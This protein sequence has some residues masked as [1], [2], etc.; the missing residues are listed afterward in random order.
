MHYTIFIHAFSYLTNNLEGIIAA[1][2]YP[3]LFLAVLLEGVPLLGTAVPGHV[4]IFVAGFLA[5]I[6]VLNLWWVL[7]IAT[8]AAI[9]GDYIGFF[10]GR[11]YGLSLID[12][13]KPYF[14]ITDD[15]INKA[16]E[17]LAK[18]TGKAMIIGRMNPLTRALMPFLV[19]TGGTSVTKFWVFNV[20]GGVIWAVGSIMIGYVLGFGYHAAAGYFGRAVVIAIVAAVLIIWGYRF[21]NMRFHIFRRY[22]LLVLALGILS[23][24]SLSKMVQDAWSPMPFMAGFD[25]WVYSFMAVHV[26]P[27]LASVANMVT[28]VGGTAVTG[29]LGILFSIYFAFRRKWRSA[30]IM[31][32]SICSASASV[33]FLKEFFMRPRPLHGLVY[34][35]PTDWS[36]PS[37]HATLAA[38][39]FFAIAYLLAP[40]IRSWVAR[41]IFVALCILSIIAIGLSRIILNV[42]W[43]SDIIAGW[44]LGIFCAASS[45][46]LVRYVGL[47]LLGDKNKNDHV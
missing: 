26:G 17:L 4:A 35:D 37:G 31:F 10:L 27:M 23:L 6:G 9:L 42:H 15:H 1:G 46:L 45:I 3:F 29:G 7:L 14:F 13:L 39:F 20:I 21:V 18:H 11:K 16:K 32:V 47:V 24:W 43:V 38:A 22:E 34:V 33:S 44:S 30:A 2:G 12:R 25:L 19:G 8:V 36:F 28:T 41:E 40:K 5:K